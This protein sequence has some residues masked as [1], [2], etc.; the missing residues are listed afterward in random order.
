MIDMTL[1]KIRMNAFRERVKTMYKDRCPEVI[2]SCGP[3]EAF[4]ISRRFY[5]LCPGCAR[6]KVSDGAT[7]SPF[8]IGK[9]RGHL[10]RTDSGG[11]VH[12]IGDPKARGQWKPRATAW[13]G[14]SRADSRRRHWACS[15]A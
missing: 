2:Y 14:A 9:T 15:C 10:A 6:L 5:S 13:R 4:G 3:C 12:K 7:G 11:A 8:T 1:S